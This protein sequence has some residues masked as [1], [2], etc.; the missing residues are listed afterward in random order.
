MHDK[1]AFYFGVIFFLI[2]MNER[3]E[4]FWLNVCEKNWS[5]P[6]VF[7]LFFPLFFINN[8][9]M[10]CLRLPRLFISKGLGRL[11]VYDLVVE[12]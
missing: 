4:F 1:I 10:S 6:Q 12:R 11:K 7:F 8:V 3:S 9:Y 5:Y 2:L